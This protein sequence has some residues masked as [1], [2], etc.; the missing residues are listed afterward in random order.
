M[1]APDTKV[2]LIA[3]ELTPIRSEFGLSFI[4]DTTFETTPALDAIFVP[5]GFGID[6]LLTDAPTLEFLASQ[7]AR[8]QWVMSVCT[9]SLLLGA[10]GLLRGYTATSHWM[11][12]E[13]LSL[14]RSLLVAIVPVK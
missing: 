5:G 9:G 10:A 1:R 2:T 3:R 11:S 13:L 6:A 12:L 7:A 8:V 4:P 14:F